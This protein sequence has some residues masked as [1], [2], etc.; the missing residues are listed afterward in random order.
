MCSFN[1][2]NNQ[3]LIALLLKE[4]HNETNCQMLI[5]THSRHFFEAI[6]ENA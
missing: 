1:H 6:K 5:S 3:R 4:L 2:P